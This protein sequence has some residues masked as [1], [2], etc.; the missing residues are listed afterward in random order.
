MRSVQCQPNRLQVGADLCWLP[1]QLEQ[2]ASQQNDGHNGPDGEGSN[3]CNQT[4]DLIHDHGDH[5]CKQAHITD[6][7]GGPLPVVHFSLDSAHSCEAG[8]TQEVE[9][10][11]GISGNSRK[12]Y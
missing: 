1:E 7:E 6:C 4:A 12:I 11:E 9:H 5:I 3:A 10:H 2:N 8:S